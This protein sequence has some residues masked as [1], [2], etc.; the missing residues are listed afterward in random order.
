[1][2]SSTGRPT[3]GNSSGAVAAAIGPSRGGSGIARSPLTAMRAELWVV[4]ALL[5]AA[6]LA[7]WS[8]ADRMVGMNAAP[9]A[10]LGS[11]GWFTGVWVMMMAAMML[12]SLAPGAAVF[13]A[14]VRREPSRVVLFAGGYLL[15]WSG[16]ASAPTACSKSA[17]NCSAARWRGTVAAAGS[18][19]ASW[20]SPRSTS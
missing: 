7:W 20:R 15:I 3:F 8:T 4:A 5:A 17:T 11:I 18:R 12:P 16:W 13:A 2:A 9:G 1:M 10:A 6:G 14:L 19:R